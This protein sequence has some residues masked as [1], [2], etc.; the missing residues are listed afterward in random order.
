MT[1]Q[2]KIDAI[3]IRRYGSTENKHAERM[4]KLFDLI[5]PSPSLKSIISIWL[6]LKKKERSIDDKFLAF[7]EKQEEENPRPIYGRLLI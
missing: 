7:L 4:R 6:G 2:E 3:L 1:T 5:Q